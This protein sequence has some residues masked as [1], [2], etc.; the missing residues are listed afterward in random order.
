MTDKC[1]FIQARMSSKRLPGKSLM[2]IS[3]YPLVVLAALRA[4]NT[5]QRVIVVT[6]E[7]KS[8]DE[9]FEIVTSYGIECFRGSLSNVLLRFKEA[10]DFYNLKKLSLIV[11]LT[12]DNIVPDGQ[13]IDELI[14]LYEENMM[15]NYIGANHPFDNLPYGVNAEVFSVKSLDEAFLSATNEFDLEHVTPWIKRHNNSLGMFLRVPKDHISY[16]SS[17]LNLTIDSQADFEVM[18]GIFYEVDRPIE[19]S[20]Y[21]I[22]RV[23]YQKFLK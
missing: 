3:G 6:S 1:I 7:D 12:A 19:E 9:L 18:K 23:A 2:R 10:S 4:G 11:R 13:L 16:I 20:W 8:D 15:V 21:K 17:K 5:G 22:T 14:E